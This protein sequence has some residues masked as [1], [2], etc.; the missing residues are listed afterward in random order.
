M[1]WD[2]LKHGKTY[3]LYHRFLDADYHFDVHQRYKVLTHHH[4]YIYI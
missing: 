3:E 2:G 1:A 4:I